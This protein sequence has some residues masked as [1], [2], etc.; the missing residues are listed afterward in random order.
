MPTAG[1]TEHG[2][3]WAHRIYL[4]CICCLNDQAL[5][6]CS[7]SWEET[8]ARTFLRMWITP[9]FRPQ[10]PRLRGQGWGSLAQSSSKGRPIIPFF[11]CPV[12]SWQEIRCYFNSKR[13][14]N[15]SY[16]VAKKPAFLR[17]HQVF[18]CFYGIVSVSVREHTRARHPASPEAVR[19]EG[20]NYR[21]PWDTTRD[22]RYCQARQWQPR[23]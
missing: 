11:P 6:S 5:G 10:L 16:E 8:V 2:P 22:A 20:R 3:P 17:V 13:L 7:C 14:M 4:V 18:L 19:P 12:R 1:G 21:L 15:K 23:H 9:G